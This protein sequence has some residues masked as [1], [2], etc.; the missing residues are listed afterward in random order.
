MTNKIEIKNLTVNYVERGV[1]NTALDGVSLT[2]KEGQFISIVGS[3]GCGKSTLLSV[4]EGLLPP[5]E[6]EALIDGVPITGPGPERGVVFQQ[7]SLFPWMTARANVLFGIRQAKRGISHKDARLLA[8][9]Y[10]GKVGLLDAAGRYPSRLSGGMQQRVAIARALAMDSDILLMDEP[11]GAVDAKNRTILQ[12]LLLEL[13]QNEAERKTVVFITH[14]LDEAI[15]LSDRI[16]LLTDSPGRVY[17]DIKVDFP[18][19]RY[20]D[21]LMGSLIYDDFR[22]ELFADFFGDKNRAAENDGVII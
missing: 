8:D 9:E 14:D 11:F 6:G 2:V 1:N 17:R 16:I 19:P 13:W 12:E 5:S 10:L 22:R 4:L 7:Y 18:R 21:E 15:F 3:S 20:R